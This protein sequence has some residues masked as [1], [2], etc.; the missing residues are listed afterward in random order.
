MLGGDEQIRTGLMFSGPGS[1][2]ESSP[3]AGKAENSSRSSES[4]TRIKCLRHKHMQVW[5]NTTM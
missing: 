5:A 1:N 4:R 3:W 2:A